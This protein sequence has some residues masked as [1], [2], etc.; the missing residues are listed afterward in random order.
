[1]KEQSVSKRRQWLTTSLTSPSRAKFLAALQVNWN[2]SFRTSESQWL[3]VRADY[4]I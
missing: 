3:K 1:M 4:V 2:W